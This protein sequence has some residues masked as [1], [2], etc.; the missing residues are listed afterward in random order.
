[1]G[2]ALRWNTPQNLWRASAVHIV[3][4]SAD[5]IFRADT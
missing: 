3:F 1:M 2:C 4:F 5:V